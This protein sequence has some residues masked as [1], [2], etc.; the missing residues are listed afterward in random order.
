MSR[1]AEMSDHDNCGADAAAYAMGALEP[2]EAEAFLRHMETCA[3]CREEVEGFTGVVRALPMAAAQYPAPSGLRRRVMREIG[4]ERYM[5]K[6][7][8]RTWPGR[9]WL[10]PRRAVLGACAAALL[11]GAVLGGE[12]L[13]GGPPQTHVYAA[14]VGDATVKVTGDRAELIVKHLPQPG[15]GKIYEVWLQRGNSAPEP[16]KALFGVDTSGSG[17]V[18]V[19]GSARGVS[20]LMVT[21]EPD[22]GRRVPTSTP[23][24]VAS[25]T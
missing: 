6:P 9:T 4:S 13:G 16:A 10:L 20:V 5:T 17:D 19:P 12:Q 11:A 14:S 2:A 25:L 21:A 18:V 1:D 7:H 8:A 23:V 22:G 24:I 3:I 15:A